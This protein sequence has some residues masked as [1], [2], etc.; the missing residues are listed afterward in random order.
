MRLP[1]LALLLLAPTVAGA[2]TQEELIQRSLSRFD[3]PPFEWTGTPDPMNPRLGIYTNQLPLDSLR[4]IRKLP[5]N[6]EKGFRI[7]HI[8]PHWSADDGG[9]YIGDIILL[10]N[11]RTIGDSSF[12]GDEYMATEAKKMP[13]GATAR[14]TLARDGKVLEVDVPLK[15]AVRTPMSFRPIDALGS[16]HVTSWLNTFIHEQNLVDWTRTIQKQMRNVADQDFCT[17]PFAGRPNPWRLNAVTYLHNY[18][19]RVG[20]TS[21]HISNDVWGWTDRAG[22]QGA[23]IAAAGHLDI[24]L[25][26]EAPKNLGSGK[27]AIEAIL[28]RTQSEIDGAF[29]LVRDDLPTMAYDLVQ[30]LNMEGNWEENLDSINDRVERRAA[31][32]RTETKLAT[33]FAKV[34]KVDVRRLFQAGAILAMLADSSWLVEKGPSLAGSGLSQPVPLIG[35]EGEVVAAWRTPQGLVVIGGRGPNRYSTGVCFLI[36]LGGDDIY[37][38]PQIAPGT[39]R[40]VADL[41]GNDLYRSDSS[42]QAAGIC[43]VDIL[44]D[45]QGDDFYRGVRWTQGAGLLGVGLLMDCDGDDVYASR[46]CSQGSGM[47]GIG[48]ILDRNGSDRYDAEVYSQAFAYARG[49]GAILEDGGNDAYRAGWKYPDDRIP[50]RA[51]L[52]MSQGFGFGL[53]PWSTGVGTDGGIGLL[54]DRHGH[55]LY[56]SDFFS[57]GGSYWYALGI[58]H[59]MEG[60]DR[61]S[62]GQYSQGSGI[63]LSFAALLDDAGD[64]AYDAYAGLE[65]GNAHDW[66]SGCLED[67]AGNDTYRG[68]NSSQGSALTVAF[69]WLLDGGG[70]DQYYALLADTS[71]SQ[72]G[73]RHAP[74]REA[75]SLGLLIDQGKGKDYYVDKR[76]VPGT[77]LLKGNKGIVLDDGE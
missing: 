37:D 60:C 45:L 41:S 14:F 3:L 58:L 66:S 23:V 16:P 72:G 52:A 40:F 1:I 57:Q 77:A 15:R 2:Q 44:V 50:G 67:A 69:A 30:V 54:C 51:H 25:T 21:R 56:A 24:P 63:H 28:Q 46:W 65:Q 36:D 64:D 17:V 12:Q 43:G 33:L 20:A 74:V 70:N 55:D 42:G 35:V 8:M 31:R 39:F 34:D 32:N 47:S 29:A 10:M 5:A 38:L 73:A 11:G 53:R 59:D 7:W 4:S 13:D 26:H 75:G 27:G 62:A 22:A 6:V 9:L 68:S 49:F 61:Y 18:P 76:V 71:Y 19:T 48:I